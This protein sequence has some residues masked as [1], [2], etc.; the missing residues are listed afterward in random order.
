[1]LLVNA[2]M[3]RNE[4]SYG[5]GLVVLQAQAVVQGGVWSNNRATK[6]GGGMMLSG[7]AANAEVRNTTFSGNSALSIGGGAM[8]SQSSTSLFLGC[9]FSSNQA[10]PVPLPLPLLLPLPL[11]LPTLLVYTLSS[12]E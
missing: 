5:A 2:V 1:M 9:V 12:A 6:A 3:D 10:L 11:P 8:Y 7:A 4:A